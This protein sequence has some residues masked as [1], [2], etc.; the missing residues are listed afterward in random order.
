[1]L[2]KQFVRALQG[3]PTIELNLYLA[4]HSLLVFINLTSYWF[5]CRIHRTLTDTDHIGLSCR[6]QER[7]FLI[8]KII[9]KKIKSTKKLS[10]LHRE[11]SARFTG[12]H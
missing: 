7:Y 9:N 3:P 11:G 1:M 6:H 5:I 12:P 4:G 2:I 10:R 8:N